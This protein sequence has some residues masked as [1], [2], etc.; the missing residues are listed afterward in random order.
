MDREEIESSLEEELS[1]MVA[2]P[3]PVE[4]EGTI[5]E[6]ESQP[7]KRGRKLI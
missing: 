5:S 3:E 2:D 7:K 4:Q 1:E 6:A